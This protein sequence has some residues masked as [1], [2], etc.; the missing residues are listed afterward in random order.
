HA[1]SAEQAGLPSVARFR[2]DLHPTLTSA[3]AGT[4]PLLCRLLSGG[5]DLL[6]FPFDIG[7]VD[8]FCERQLL[9]QKPAGL[10]EQSPLPETEVLV[11]LQSIHVAE[12]LGDLDREPALQHFGVGAEAPIPG[13]QID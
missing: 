10:V 6:D 9:N 13:L 7:A 3:L 12:H 1:D 4:R 11:E 5:E 8:L 2:V